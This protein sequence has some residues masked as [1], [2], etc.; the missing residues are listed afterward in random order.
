MATHPTA[1]QTLQEAPPAATLVHAGHRIPIRAGGLSIGRD[2]GN[3]LCLDDP[4][5]SRRHARIHLDE[6]EW[7][8]TD[9]G[10]V[11]GTRLGEERIRGASRAVSSG[12]VVT[13][14]G[15][16]MRFLAG[17][18]TVFGGD[19]AE[20]TAASAQ[21]IAF[22]GEPVRIG[23]DPANDLVLDDPNVSRLHAVLERDGSRVVIRDLGSRNGTRVGGRLV[24]TG[25][26]TAGAEIGIGPY[27]LV[28]DGAK[29]LAQDE[30]GHLR[31]EADG[32]E[33]V[34]G[35]LR[36]LESTR[37]SVRPGELVAVIGESGSGKSTLVKTLAGVRPPSAGSV[38]ING[39]P[40]STRRTDLGYVP[41]DDIV[42]GRLTVREALQ[43]AARLRLPRDAT[44][45]DVDDAVERVLEE[46]GLGERA[47]V[48]IDALSG[49]QRKRVGVATE[50]LGRPGLLFLDEPTTGLDPALESRLMA[51]LRDLADDTRAVVVVTHATRSLRLCDRVVVMG[52]GGV[53]CFDGSPRDALP[54]FEVDDFDEIYVALGERPATEWR[55]RFGHARAHRPTAPRAATLPDAVPAPRRRPG[56]AWAH[57]K[58][59]A[60]R[61]LVLLGRDR[62][63]LVIL[64]GQ[65]PLL[66]LAIALLFPAATLTR[67]PGG[68][69]GNAAQFLFFLITTVIWMGSIA[70]AREIV[71]ERTVMDRERAIGV[72]P[73]A[74]LASKLMVLAPLACAQV[75]LS[76]IVACGLRPLG[77]PLGAYVALALI[78]ALTG[79]A[80][81]AMGLTVSSLVR[82]EEQATSAIPLVLVP[83]LL[84]GG[85]IVPVATMTGA[86]KAL[87]MLVFARWSFAGAGT[88]IDLNA[89]IAAQGGRALVFGADFFVVSLPRTCALL[90]AFSAAFVA[91]TLWRLGRRSPA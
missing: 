35:G 46:L 38:T 7:R 59:L 81:V 73:P 83:S 79:L 15:Q 88:A 34:A 52:A 71:R 77:E 6:G 17:H 37:L 76:M 22:A 54:F 55:E 63:N 28:F 65:A 39:E 40:V 41:Q 43:Y 84:F 26:V 69:P 11:N 30:R 4:D 80:A 56:E 25:E 3:D 45:A 62:R 33:V 29:V 61:Y 32:V 57:A 8:L 58:L 2:P 42:H 18:E 85:A 10:S 24:D 1:L 9:L 23:R 74:Y 31:L 48:R 44:P 82:G 13:I 49:G 21:V 75:A 67:G 47:D 20:A 60:R 72:T 64:L 14:G 5:V 89:R 16:A 91:L 51:L 87:S 68:S 78:L 36:I 12:D 90:I 27:R 50:L 70:A 66:A 86:L 53:M 19:G